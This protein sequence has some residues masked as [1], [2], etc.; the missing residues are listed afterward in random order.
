MSRWRRHTSGWGK[1]ASSSFAGWF[2]VLVFTFI[3]FVS[4][5][6]YCFCFFSN[7]LFM[8]GDPDSLL[9]FVHSEDHRWPP[10]F[11]KPCTNSL[12]SCAYVVDFC[13][14]VSC[15]SFGNFLNVCVRRLKEMRPTGDYSNVFLVNAMQLF[16][17]SH[18]AQICESAGL[19]AFPSTPTVMRHCRIPNSKLLLKQQSLGRFTHSHAHALCM[20]LCF[21]V[22]FASSFVERFSTS[23]Q[24]KLG[25]SGLATS[26][27]PALGFWARLTQI[28]SC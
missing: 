5:S 13:N 15:S 9:L 14:D 6:S 16:D 1:C 8:N 28:P 27:Y 24:V 21:L 3:W 20:K 17:D 26:S 7:W 11:D 12:L 18:F 10:P 2:V 22:L 23:K 4:T 25:W 19:T